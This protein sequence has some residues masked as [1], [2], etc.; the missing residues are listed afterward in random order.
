MVIEIASPVR[1]MT[2]TGIVLTWTMRNRP[3]A[4]ECQGLTAPGK[5]ADWRR[6]TLAW[7]VPWEGWWLRG[8]GTMR[9]VS[10]GDET[11]MTDRT[12]R[13]DA[14]PAWS[15]QF[16]SHEDDEATLGDDTPPVAP[17]RGSLFA[18]KSFAGGRVQ[19]YGC[20]PKFL[21]LS[22]LLS[23]LLTILLNVLF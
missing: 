6:A 12:P 10:D 3:I 14:D 17:T 2:V 4:G 20:S 18:P 16:R 5:I 11:T 23:L 9:W 21:L 15:G 13:S 22:L 19:V 1:G 7:V 8:A